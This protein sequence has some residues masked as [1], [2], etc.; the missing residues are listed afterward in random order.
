MKLRLKV[1]A[2]C[3]VVIGAIGLLAFAAL[4]LGFA[5]AHDPE[6]NDEFAW[7]GGGMGMLTLMFFLPS[8]VSGIALLRGNPWGRAIIWIE[9]ALLALAVPVGTVICG[10]SLWVLL[11][12]WDPAEAP[13]FSEIE[14]FVQNSLRTIVLMLIALFILGVIL[15]LGYIFRDVIAPPQPQV[16][17]PLPSGVPPRIDPPEFRMP[18]APRAPGQ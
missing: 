6:Y 15:G 17:T 18:E 5:M 1:L 2:W 16:L 11:T 10:V 7:M 12:T 3:H 14:R 13:T 9:S 4:V 8:F